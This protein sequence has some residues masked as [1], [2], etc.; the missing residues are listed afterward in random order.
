MQL[1]YCYSPLLYLNWAERK[2]SQIKVNSD[3]IVQNSEEMY[4]F[5]EGTK[6]SSDHN[7]IFV[8]VSLATFFHS[9]TFVSYF[10]STKTMY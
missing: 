4:G 6:A 8:E 9:Y 2:I 7:S 3:N 1:F 5:P 10:F